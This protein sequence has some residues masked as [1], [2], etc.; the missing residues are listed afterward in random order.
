[1][2][3]DLRQSHVTPMHSHLLP[4]VS[5]TAK[6]N[7]SIACLVDDFLAINGAKIPEDHSKESQYGD[8]DMAQLF[9]VKQDNRLIIVEDDQMDGYKFEEELEEA[10]VE[11]YGIKMA[12][13]TPLAT[14]ELAWLAKI[15]PHFWPRIV[16]GKWERGKSLLQRWRGESV[17]RATWSQRKWML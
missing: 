5:Q 4:G 2:P 12:M 1:M 7:S 11:E 9:E 3:R 6:R 16:S 14:P 15:S 13:P 8:L 10:D 17:D